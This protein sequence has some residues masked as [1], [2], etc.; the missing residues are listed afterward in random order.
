MGEK[1]ISQEDY[2]ESGAKLLESVG[3]WLLLGVRRG[4][5]QTLMDFQETLG[6]I[7]EAI[8]QAWDNI[9]GQGDIGFSEG[10]VTVQ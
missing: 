8:E 5:A 2:I 3:L 9:Q 7:F 6:R 4:D 10:K 1:R